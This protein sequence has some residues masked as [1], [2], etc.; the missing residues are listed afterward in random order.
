MQFSM[1]LKIREFYSPG[2]PTFFFD[3]KITGPLESLQQT[4]QQTA[5]EFI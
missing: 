2:S 5:F 1:Q 3:E 4:G